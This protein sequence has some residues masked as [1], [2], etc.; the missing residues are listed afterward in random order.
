MLKRSEVENLIGDFTWDFGRQFFI[1]TNKGNFVWSDPDYNGDNK[2]TPY[3]GSYKD[4]IKS[5]RYGRDKG[6]HR[7]GDYCENF[8]YDVDY[9]YEKCVEI[10]EKSICSIDN[11]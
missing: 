3:D 10:V 9:L 8:I 1:E 11:K 6:K 4:W 5:P 2:L 7:I